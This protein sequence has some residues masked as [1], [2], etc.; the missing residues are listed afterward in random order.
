MRR[1]LVKRPPQPLQQGQ[2][3]LSGNAF[4]AVH[5]AGRYCK[6]L[7]WPCNK[8][9]LLVSKSEMHWVYLPSQKD[10]ADMGCLRNE[11]VLSSFCK[12]LS[13]TL[14]CMHKSSS[15]ALGHGH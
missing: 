3:F 15:G 1:E 5:G 11:W 2:V 4:K 14:S 8:M 7:Q 13:Q 9:T 10:S 12:C 6:A